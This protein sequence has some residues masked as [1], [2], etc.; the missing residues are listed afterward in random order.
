MVESVPLSCWLSP[1]LLTI[2]VTCQLK[3][4]M[5]VLTDVAISLKDLT[6]LNC[7]I[8]ENSIAVLC[9]IIRFKLEVHDFWF[10]YDLDNF[11]EIVS[12]IS[13]SV[14]RLF[15]PAISFTFL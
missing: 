15:L 10:F 13:F 12:I 8:P 11:F 14:S 1:Q 2:I 5:F 9:P 6:I 7:V 4:E 3:C